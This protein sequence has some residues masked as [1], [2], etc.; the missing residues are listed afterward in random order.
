[1]VPSVPVELPIDALLGVPP[2]QK[3]VEE[4]HFSRKEVSKSG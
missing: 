2:D 1:M 4:F 3:V